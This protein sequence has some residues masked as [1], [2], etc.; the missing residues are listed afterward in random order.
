[1]FY[2]NIINCVSYH[3]Q[4]TVCVVS[5]QTVYSVE[6]EFISIVYGIRGEV[7]HINILKVWKEVFSILD[8]FRI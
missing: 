5:S 8:G 4:R 7:A 3:K 2:I 6:F 1:M